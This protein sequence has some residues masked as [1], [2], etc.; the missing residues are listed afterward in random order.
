MNKR[1][2]SFFLLVVCLTLLS[3]CTSHKPSVHKKTRPLM[4]TLV[5]ITVVSDSDDKAAQAIEKAFSVIDRFGKLINFFSEDSELSAINRNAGIK[6]VRVSPETIDVIE[7]AVYVA[8]KS[9]GAFDA[10]IGP[11]SR[12]WDFYKKVKPSD[13][14]IRK[15]LDLVNYRDIVLDREKSTVFLRRK[16]MMMDLGGIAKGYAAD[17]AVEN[18]RQNGI[19]AGI[20]A[21]AGDIRVFGVKP[22]GSPWNIGVKNPRQKN[23]SDE[24]IAR[25]RLTDKAISTS[26]DYERYFMAD[27]KR[28]HHIL[29]PKTGYP[30]S[31]CR[32]V[33][34]ITDKGVFTDGFS[35]AVFVL[36]PDKG[37]ELVRETGMDAVIIDSNGTIFT[38]PGMKGIL[39]I[40]ENH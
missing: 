33:T 2:I 22:D 27:G 6:G 36:G 30:A 10:T 3:S 15:N 9:D 13:D 14:E 25:V 8:E 28:F 32:S 39:T 7:K 34:I 23:E 19:R 21:N 1:R 24:L 29:D 18:L 11:E 4:D 40:E 38:T 12:L 20:V 37:M 31:Y 35:T 26:G 17:L 16:G 5:T